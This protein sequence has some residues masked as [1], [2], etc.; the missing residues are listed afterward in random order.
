MCSTLNILGL[1]GSIK[2]IDGKLVARVYE[3]DIE[4][5]VKI[6]ERDD[7]GTRQAICREIL[8]ANP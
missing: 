7:D 8:A 4:R 1:H 6:A 2:T 3:A 5:M